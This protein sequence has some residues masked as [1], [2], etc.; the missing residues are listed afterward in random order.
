MQSGND[1]APRY[2]LTVSDGRTVKQAAVTPEGVTVGREA[3]RCTIAFEHPVLSRTHCFVGIDQAGALYVQDRGSTNGVFV[4]GTR[5]SAAKVLPGTQIFLGERGL[6]RVTVEEAAP[7]RRA[8]PLAYESTAPVGQVPSP[9]PQQPLPPGAMLR[10]QP[11]VH[12]K[13][14]PPPAARPAPQP[15][16][17]HEAAGTVI[18]T[19]ERVAPLAARQSVVR[20]SPNVT[21][22]GRSEESD[23]VLDH[24]LVSRHH[25]KI[26]REV[27]RVVLF[28]LGSANGTFVDGRRVR[29]AAIAPGDR[30]TIGPFSYVLERDD[31]LHGVA[32]FSLVAHSLEKRVKDRA[33]L[34]TILQSVTFEA[35]QSKFIGL[36]GPSG[37]GKSTLLGILS[38]LDRRFGGSVLFDGVDLKSHYEEL[39]GSI[40]YVPQ[41][42]I[43]HTALTPN[44]ALYYT[45]KLR[46]PPDNSEA[47]IAR[48]VGA[49]LEELRLTE[50]KDVKI[51]DP[52][53]KGISG[54]QRKRVSLGQELL[55]KPRILLL[56]EPTSGLDP[57][58]ERDVMDLLKRVAINNRTVFI[59]THNITKHNFELLD[60]VIILAKGLPAYYGP[61]REAAAY[62]GVED[63]ADIFVKLETKPP[64]EWYRRYAESGAYR[65]YVEGIRAPES[66]EAE[67]PLA[68]DVT[69]GS[70][71]RQ[72]WTLTRRYANIKVYDTVQTAV[73]LAQA[74]VIAL[75]LGI[76]F[77]TKKEPYDIANFLFVSL[78]STLWFG[79]SGAIREV[80]SERAIYIRERAVNL[81]IPSYILS[82]VGVLSFVALVQCLVLSSLSVFLLSE[83]TR[84]LVID[85]PLRFLHYNAILFLTAF[86]GIG[87][88]LFV[89]ALLN[90]SEGALGVVPLVLIPQIIFGGVLVKLSTLGAMQWLAHLTMSKWSLIAMTGNLPPTVRD[91]VFLYLYQ[92][93]EA[94][95][96]TL[97]DVWGYMAVLGGSGALLV[98]GAGLAL[99]IKEKLR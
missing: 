83:E 59:A 67:T 15:R 58:T 61:G 79:M 81:R 17:P 86:S 36:I 77:K 30:V 84:L 27:N 32:A 99:W 22:F 7:A 25:A 96:R 94:P 89:S 1:R 18:A 41:D 57:L 6:V 46:L 76:I 62:F 11:A 85:P 45:A 43:V 54:G 19:G 8:E 28:D 14:A 64:E 82:K 71:I 65:T 55:T 39:K 23:V 2:V 37:C 69:K 53:K 52:T 87:L 50:G 20:L 24:P 33:G 91:V 80:V 31:T 63:P 49:V 5:V 48:L 26:V 73:L 12:A 75:I 70:G 74:P 16:P 10:P 13:A 90:S 21:T 40:G 98:A 38:G 42:D 47:D 66:P 56:D 35:G 60:F 92:G 97:P 95:Q 51:G 29:Q 72:W 44:Q 4:N 3:G 88:G 93:L 34:K 78:L 9:A 68:R